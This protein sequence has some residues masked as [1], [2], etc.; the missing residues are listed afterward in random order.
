MVKAMQHNIMVRDLLEVPTK[1][2][3]VTTLLL[4]RVVLAHKTTIINSIA[5]AKVSISLRIN[6]HSLMLD[7]PLNRISNITNTIK[8]TITLRH[9]INNMLLLQVSPIT[10]LASIVEVRVKTLLHLS[11]PPRR[12]TKP[13][14]SNATTIT[15]VGSILRR[16]QEAFRT[17]NSLL[18]LQKGMK[19]KLTMT[20]GEAI[21]AL[22]MCL[23]IIHVARKEMLG[24]V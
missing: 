1:D 11:S 19:K 10:K 6:N 13:T 7:N 22:V 21:F 14:T 4:T 24:F 12:N 20:R 5:M 23:I 3:A 2:E 15:T 17:T 9:S 8:I 16:Q 18:K